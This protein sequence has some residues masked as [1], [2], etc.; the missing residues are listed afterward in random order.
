MLQPTLF[1]TTPA[2]IPPEPEMRDVPIFEAPQP[3]FALRDYQVDAVED[4]LDAIYRGEHPVASCPTGSGK[5]LIIAALCERI[6]GRILVATHRKELLQQNSGELDRYG[7]D[8]NFGIYSAGLKTRDTDARIIFGGIQSIYRRMQELQ[9]AGPF[10]VIIADEAHLVAAKRTAVMWEAV[11]AACPD[12]KRIGLTATPYRLDSGLLHQTKDGWFTEMPVHVTIR[13][14]TPAYLAPLTGTLTANG[15]NVEQVRVRRGDYVTRE[16]SQVAS[17][18]QAVKSAVDEMCA[19]AAGRRSILIF[20]VDVHHA[21]LVTL[22]MKNRGMVVRLVVGTTPAEERAEILEAFRA[23][24]IEAVVSV[25]VMTTGMNIPGIDCIAM[26]RPTLSKSLVV[27]MVGRGCRHAPGKQ[28][29]LVLDFAGNLERHVPLDGLEVIR[30]S[31]QREEKDAEE[32]AK[33]ERERQRQARHG[34]Q[35]SDIDP[36]SSEGAD[37]RKLQVLGVSYECQDSRNPRYAGRQIFVVR[38]FCGK[39]KG[40]KKKEWISQWLCLEYTGWAR[41]IAAQWFERRGLQAPRSAQE[42]YGRRQS[43]QK[44]THIVVRKEGQ[45]DKVLIEQFPE[46]EEE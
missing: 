3:V 41:M 43:Y 28:D 18:E 39:G 27:Q 26:L 30:K 25:E 4:L 45:W 10:A 31:R 40:R 9:Q 8:D 22:E 2:S 35:S 29:C 46:T 33:Q 19:L 34:S 24:R 20:C 12:A 1:N 13:E 15:V 17:E 16:L 32:A 42:A 5:S 37:T 36:M 6:P 38:Y 21:S 44:P 23:Q 14:L 7:D 11:F